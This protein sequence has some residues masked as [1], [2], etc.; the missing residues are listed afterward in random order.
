LGVLWG[1]RAEEVAASGVPTV[2]RP[3]EVLAFVG[4][5]P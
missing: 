2:R 5:V 1:F 3:E 4:R